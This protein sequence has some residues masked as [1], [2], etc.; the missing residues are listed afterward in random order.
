MFVIAP[1]ALV[2]LAGTATGTL[3]LVDS[4]FCA[5]HDDSCVPRLVGQ[6][7]HAPGR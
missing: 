4:M 6:A 3:L 2:V 7:R 1:L 5:W